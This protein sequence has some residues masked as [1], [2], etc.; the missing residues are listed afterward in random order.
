MQRYRPRNKGYRPGTGYYKQPKSIGH[1][2]VQEKGEQ[3]G[4][5]DL[6]TE[7]TPGI[8][9]HLDHQQGD[10]QEQYCCIG[11]AVDWRLEEGIIPVNSLSIDL[12]RLAMDSGNGV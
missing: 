4:Q 8:G 11:S 5:Q 9:N 7:R 1:G 6:A 10:H 3:A 2:V 12:H